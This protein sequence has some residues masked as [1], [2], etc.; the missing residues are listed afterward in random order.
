M[1]KKLSVFKYAPLA[2]V[3]LVTGVQANTFEKEF[4]VS[5]GGLLKIV[6]DIGA[7]EID[8]HDK[9]YGFNRG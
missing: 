6:T 1:N 9:K 7:I 2:L 4:K 3:L 5:D 8:S